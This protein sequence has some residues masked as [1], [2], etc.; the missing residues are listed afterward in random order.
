MSTVDPETGAAARC[1]IVSAGVALLLV[2]THQLVALD[3]WWQLATGKWI[4]THGLPRVDPFSF[5]FPDRPWVEQRWLFFVT[6]Y[7]IAELGGLNALIVAKWAWLAGCFLLLERAM[8]PAPVWAR[9]FGLTVAVVL[10]HSRLKVRPELVSYLGVIG[11]LWVYECQ[12][13]TGRDRVLLALPALQLLWSNS[14]TLWI[15]GPALAWTAWGVEAVLARAPGFAG[16]IR[17]QPALAPPRRRALLRVALAVTLAGFVTPYLFL[18]EFYPTTILEQIGVGSQLRELIVELQSPLGL[19]GD[20]IF[21]GSYLAVLALS[22]GALLLPVRAPAI[23]IVIW[24][25]FVG[26]SLLA[27]RNVSLLGP[28]AGWVIAQQ[29]GDASTELDAAQRRR[30]ARAATTLALVGSLGL[31]WAAVTDRLWRGRGWHQRFGTGVREALYPMEALAFAAQ[32]ALPQP[33]LSSLADASFVIHQ[34]GARS[35]F[36]DGRLEVYGAEAILENARK[37]GEPGGV[38]ADADEQG[39]DTVL[40]AFPLMAH[41]VDDFEAHPDWAPVF[42]DSRRILYLRRT[43]ATAERVARFEL[44]WDRSARP[45]AR[46]ADW[47][48]P[49]DWAAGWA[50][51]VADASEPFGRAMLLLGRGARAAGRRA[52]L[53]TVEFDPDHREAW[54]NL[55]LLA[56]VAGDA[57]VAEEYMEHVPPERRSGVD[58]HEARVALA[59]GAGDPVRHFDVALDAL[60]VG[61]RSPG[62]LAALVDGASDPERAERARRALRAALDSG[63][64]GSERAEESAALR[65]ALRALAARR[66]DRAQ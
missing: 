56:E 33:V 34:Q 23:R 11:F 19:V 16:R 22:F 64:E 8:R 58:I 60:A 45:R 35:V 20:P 49:P 59:R 26:F 7:A 14:H 43:P 21:F 3:L 37:W 48:E 27:A 28:V 57:R 24:A 63:P 47:L 61:A 66:T 1:A 30:W 5:G 36:I 53:E 2:A 40:L 52:L 50:P 41:A 13:R 4:A 54:I 6:T 32:H 38:R 31:S 51:R 10:L 17:V 9:A 62:V 29:L 25:G 44:D 12:R 18:G 55:A 15:A 39:I 65:A 42:Y 46:I